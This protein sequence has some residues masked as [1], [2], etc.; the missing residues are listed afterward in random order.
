MR[1][2][3]NRMVFAAR[4]GAHVRSGHVGWRCRIGH[5]SH[6]KAGCVLNNVTMGR[7]CFVNRGAELYA[8]DVGDYVSIGHLAQ[9]GPN[10]HLT[11]EITTCNALYDDVLGKKLRARN[12]PR[13]T[14]G[15]DVWIG[16]RAIVLRGVTVAT[17]AII[18]AG[19]VVVRDVEPYGIV[20]GA[21]AQLLRQRFAPEL[22]DRLM[23]SRWWEADPSD[24]R[25][26]VARSATAASPAE[27][28]E[29]FLVALP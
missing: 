4:T 17:G 19:A 29:A 16:S 9:I 6:I 20:L 15:H 25:R 3:L 2:L 8:S 21:P 27:K 12:V 26:A 7:D 18:G 1:A 24:V 14:I 11:D 28:V 23:A 13:T 10:E 5:G 22:V